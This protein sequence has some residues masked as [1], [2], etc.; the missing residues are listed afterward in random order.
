MKAEGIPVTLPFARSLSLL[1]AG[2]KAAK[3][4]SAVHALNSNSEG[5]WGFGYSSY[6]SQNEQVDWS[7]FE[8]NILRSYKDQV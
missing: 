2:E 5:I 7:E 6:L 3:D 1:P 8:L 4:D